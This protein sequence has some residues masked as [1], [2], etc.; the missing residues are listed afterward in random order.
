MI[1]GLTGPNASGKGE[2]ANILKKRNFKYYS[3]SDIIREEAEKRGLE[4]TREILINIGNELREKFG[5]NYLAQKILEKINSDRQTGQKDFVVDSIR[6]PFEVEELKTD[7]EFILF[8][9][10]APIESRYER[11]KARGR[12][13]NAENFYE[14]KLIEEKENSQNPKAQQQD[15]V[16][17]MADKYVYNDGNLEDLEKRFDFAL[18]YTRKKRPNW[19]Q[20][21][22]NI[23]DIIATRASCLKRSVGT[24]LVKDKQI[25]STGYNGPPKGHPTCDEIGGCLRINHNII[26]GQ[27]QEVC[28]AVHSEQNAISQAAENGISTKG[29][30]LYCTTFPCIICTRAIINAGIKKI[31]Y[32]ESY[33]DDFSAEIA[34]RSGIELVQFKE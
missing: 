7:K 2:L 6:N 23:A 10:N 13:E 24:V 8:G 11:A 17:K 26:S 28:R 19:D 15:K 22:M 1:I 31:I 34:K 9:I 14:F 5:P 4:K 25:I 33:P 27:K 20:Y 32:K 18:N 30:T 21:F 16:Y 29:A 3:C 12:V